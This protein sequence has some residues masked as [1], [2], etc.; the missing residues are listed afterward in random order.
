MSSSTATFLAFSCYTAVLTSLLSSNFDQSPIT[1]LKDILDLDYNLIVL[2]G[3]ANYNL[4]ANDD[5]RKRKTILSEIFASLVQDEPEAL[6]ESNEEAVGRLVR[7]PKLV[8]F[9]SRTRFEEDPRVVALKISDS[10]RDPL[11]LAFQ[12]NSEFRDL[13]DYHLMKLA[14][15]GVLSKLEYRGGIDRR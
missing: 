5:G 12:K 10:L 13:F 9:S 8:D 15:A 1:S 4:M 2:K 6:Y 7:D 14:E 3:S 11:G